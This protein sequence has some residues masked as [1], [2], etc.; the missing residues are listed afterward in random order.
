MLSAQSVREGWEA[1]FQAMAEAE[2]DCLLD[3]EPLVL[4]QWEANEWLW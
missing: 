3:A 2:D 4:T 1:Q